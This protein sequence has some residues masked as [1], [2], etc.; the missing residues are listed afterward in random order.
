[1]AV[2]RDDMAK[3]DCY[4]VLGVGRGAD[5][6]TI[7]KAYRKLAKKYHPDTSAG[8]AQAEEKFKEATQAYEILSD[9]KKRKLYDQFGHAAFDGSGAEPGGPY[10]SPFED[11][12]NFGKSGAYS[13][14][15]SGQAAGGRDGAGYRYE[16]HFGGDGMD[17]MDDILKNM[18]GGGRQEDFGKKGADLEA[19]IS[20]SFEEAAFGCE[21]TVRLD[22]GNNGGQKSLRVRIP[23]GIDN[24]KS[25]RL[26]GKGGQG[27][28]GGSPGDIFL[29]VNVRSKPGFER[30]GMDVYTVADIPFATAVFGGEAMVETLSGSVLCKIRE[31]TQSGTK[32]RLKGKGIVSMKDPKVHGDQYVTIQI[33][34]PRQLGEEARRKLKEFQAACAGRDGACGRA[35]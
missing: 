20:V 15:K 16:Y 27:R 19:E 21:K 24:G 28:N 3:R 7:K 9:P 17:D 18:F 34:V 4:E 12:F 22:A 35:G 5:E 23:A 1:M 25:I 13:G 6:Q 32:I 8:N 30:Q 29:R 33:Q 10:G 2:Q 14:G 26:K 11:I 31:G